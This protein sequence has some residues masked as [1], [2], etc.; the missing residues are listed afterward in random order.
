MS[1]IK[2]IAVVSMFFVGVF[3]Y[4]AVNTDFFG[5]KVSRAT[6]GMVATKYQVPSGA[7]DVISISLGGTDKGPSKN[8]AYLMEDCSVILQ[9]YRDGFKGFMDSTAK[10][11]DGLHE[12][13][14]H[15]CMERKQD[16]N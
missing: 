9:E 10:L 14:Q 13:K 5:R 1:K 12:F 4:W 11:M 6:M 2:T 8:I 16:K 15:Q 3:A 7:T